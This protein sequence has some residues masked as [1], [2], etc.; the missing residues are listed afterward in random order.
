MKNC[1]E[2]SL[3]FLFFTLGSRCRCILFSTI[4]L[5]AKLLLLLMCDMWT[6]FMAVNVW[7]GRMEIIHPTFENFISG[8][9]RCRKGEGN[10][11]WKIWKFRRVHRAAANITHSFLYMLSLSW[12]DVS[13]ISRWRKLIASGCLTCSSRTRRRATSTTSSCQMYIFVSS[14]TVLYFT[15]SEFHW[16]SRARWILSCIH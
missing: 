11:P 12:Q 3:N 6:S 13:N 2:N 9:E 10:F 14:H 15:V 7:R 8:Q 5:R 16:H 1:S 4:H